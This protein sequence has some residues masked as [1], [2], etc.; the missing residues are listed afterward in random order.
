M[1]DVVKVIETLR[2]QLERLRAAEKFVR[3]SFD[4]ETRE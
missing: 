3:E 1:K 2:T 4:R